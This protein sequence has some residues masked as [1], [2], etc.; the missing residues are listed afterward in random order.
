[1]TEAQRVH[2]LGRELQLRLMLP[3]LAIVIA[4][5]A[6]GAYTANRLTHQVF[7]RWLLDAAY[8]LAQ[9]VRFDHGQAQI[10]LPP[11]AAT[12]LA[13]DDT[14]QTYYSVV[15][16]PRL[17]VG[18][19][20]LPVQG[21][22]E[23][24]Y[25]RG[26]AFDA[27]IGGQAVRVV[28]VDVD[29][30]TGHMAT[31]SMAETTLKRERAEQDLRGI[32]WPVAA[33]VL[34]AFAAILW[35]VRRTLQPLAAIA[36]RWNQRTQASLQP[37]AADDL[38]RELLPFAQALNALLARIRAM[39]ERE[40]AFAANA[41]HQL[42]TP[43]AGLQLGLARA[44]EAPDLASARQV[45]R[46]L[47]DATQRHARLVQQMLV[48]SRLD[49]EMRGDRDFQPTDLVALAQGVGAAY[50]DAAI[51][52]GIRLELV[53]PPQ[54]VQATVQ[55]ELL[56]EALG[57]LLDNALRYTPAG[58]RVRVEFELQPPAISVAD[59]G[60]GTPPA[61]RAAIFERFVRGKGAPG[62]GSGLG[63]AIVRDIATLH[64]A[65][66]TRD[67]GALGG[68]RYTLRFGAAPASAA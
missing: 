32:L 68:S 38:P 10:D 30:G 47:S 52:K 15:Q 31:V 44:A 9:L 20:G 3:L 43:L 55:P 1:M 63:L 64:G 53:A 7:D 8:S 54:P 28:T 6:L 34:T 35:V 50:A 4:T 39:L 16:G 46:E 12:V 65:T 49:P 24:H 56:A 48:L 17:L 41:A 40:R 26:R 67:D 21:R 45:L 60:I 51:A 23:T 11:A 27:R 57:N 58:G 19:A 14:D 59:S 5:A 25:P 62:E 22:D 29:D 18:Q 36:T 13:Y 61:E 2:W 42:R 33:L 37:L 66:V